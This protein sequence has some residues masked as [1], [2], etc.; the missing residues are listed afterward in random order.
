MDYLEEYT[1]KLSFAVS[2][3][4]AATSRVDR[5]EES[6][7]GVALGSRAHLL[8]SGSGVA[9]CINGCAQVASFPHVGYC[10][11]TAS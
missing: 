3:H 2:H 4:H 6:S 5:Q 7:I 9:A 8:L 10:N 1:Q 11:Q